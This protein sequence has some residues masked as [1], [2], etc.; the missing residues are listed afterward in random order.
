MPAPKKNKK[1]MFPKPAPKLQKT[2][3]TIHSV[4]VYDLEPFIEAVTGQKYEC[5]C[6]EEWSN[7]SQHRIFVDGKLSEW[8]QKDWDDFK[9]LGKRDPKRCSGQ[10]FL[11]HVIMNGLCSDG[12][13]EAGLY[14]ITVC[15]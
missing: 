10:G 15:W 8:D 5:V 13:I 2:T 14:L 1:D 4:D 12:K 3:E 7:D 11:L 6:E 9:S